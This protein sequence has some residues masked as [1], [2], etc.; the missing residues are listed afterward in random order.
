MA[1][2]LG[3]CLVFKTVVSHYQRNNTHSKDSGWK[4]QIKKY[5]E[6]ATVEKEEH[7]GIKSCFEELYMFI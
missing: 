6:A 5:S 3:M 4:K 2:V 7:Q 1:A